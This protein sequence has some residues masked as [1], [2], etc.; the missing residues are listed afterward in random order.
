MFTNVLMFVVIMLVMLIPGF[1][2]RKVNL[3]KAGTASSFS[4]LLLYVC[5]PLLIF[6]SLLYNPQKIADPTNPNLIKGMLITFAISFVAIFMVFFIAKIVFLKHRERS[7]A[8]AY[9]FASVF[10]NVAFIGIPFLQYILKNDPALP[11]TLVY[12]SIFNV[13][14]NILCWTLGV[15]IITGNFKSLSPKKIL[16]NP[17]IIVTCIALPLFFLKVNIPLYA[18]PV[19]DIISFLAGMTTPLSMIIVGMRLADFQFRGIVLDGY[20]YLGSFCR[21]IVAP[22]FAFG[23]IMLLKSLNVFG[24]EGSEFYNIYGKS[25]CMAVLVLSALPCAASTIAFCERFDGDSKTAVKVFMNSTFLAL[26]TLPVLISFMFG[27]L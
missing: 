13:V 7:V 20:A 12:A 27:F 14:F 8:N 9:T 5:S 24:A 1:I 23:L 6:Q 16:L 17:I 15:Y 22:L 18:Q 19:S 3:I 11:Y 4:A 25:I 26:I 2:L 21:L 10:G